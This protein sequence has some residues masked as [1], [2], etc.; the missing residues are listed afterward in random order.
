MLSWLVKKIRKM[1]P[2]VKAACIA[3]LGAV[4]GALI[5]GTFTYVTQMKTIQ[6][7]R[8]QMIECEDRRNIL[9]QRYRRIFQ[10]APE[11]FAGDL[12]QL[13]QNATA[14][15]ELPE[16]ASGEVTNSRAIVSARD[17]LRSVLDAVGN[18]LDSDIDVLKKELEKPNPDPAKLRQTLEVLRLKWPAKKHEIELAVRKI[19]TEMGFVPDISEY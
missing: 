2:N 7:Q 19:E 8:R 9:V 16:I 11:K 10:A 15:P 17:G 3:A 5:A 12:N 6:A 14:Q 13:I 18:R 1:S 4:L